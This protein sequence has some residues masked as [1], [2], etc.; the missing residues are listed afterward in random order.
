MNRRAVYPL[1]KAVQQLP[2]RT[3]NREEAPAPI[4]RAAE[5]LSRK[6]SAQPIRCLDLENVGRAIAEES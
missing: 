6:S 5:Q 3:D 1:T 2:W 4:I